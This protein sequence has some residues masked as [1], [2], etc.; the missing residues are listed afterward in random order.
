MFITLFFGT[1][2]VV[3]LFSMAKIWCQERRDAREAK[4]IKT[5]RI[6]A[7]FRPNRD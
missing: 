1:L 2:F 4:R 3:G 5:A 6:D 7:Y